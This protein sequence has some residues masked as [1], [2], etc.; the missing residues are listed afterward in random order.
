M[1][2]RKNKCLG[3]ICRYVVLTKGAVSFPGLLLDIPFETTSFF[4]ILIQE[5]EQFYFNLTHNIIKNNRS[6]TKT[7]IVKI[8]Y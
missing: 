2:S 7:Y 3:H 4:S 1:T 8:Y 5:F 6:S